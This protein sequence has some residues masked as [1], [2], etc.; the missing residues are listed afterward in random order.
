MEKKKQNKT[1]QN[2]TKKKKQ[3]LEGQL[4]RVHLRTKSFHRL[5]RH[6]VKLNK[7]L[8]LFKA[9]SREILLVDAV[10]SG[11]VVLINNSKVYLRKIS[12]ISTLTAVI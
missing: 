9:F 4:N 10:C 1:K 3:R 5:L 7:L 8:S 12:S 6:I 2:K 11:G